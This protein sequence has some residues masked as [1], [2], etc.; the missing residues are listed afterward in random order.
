MRLTLRQRVERTIARRVVLDALA[1][2]WELNVNN[3]GDDHELPRFTRKA[4]EV[5]DA[6]FAT[7]EEYLIL[8]KPAESWRP[9][10]SGWVRFIYGNDGW[11]V[12]NDYTTNLDSVMTTANRLA[13][14]Y[15]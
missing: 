7:D 4:K 12:V 1:A 15:Q 13:E 2:G 9:T 3:G 6:M 8:R 14:K 5:L 11:D 10:L